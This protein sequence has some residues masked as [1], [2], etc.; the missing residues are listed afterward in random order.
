AVR[1]F[2]DRASRQRKTVAAYGASNT[3]TTLMYHFELTEDIAFLID[4]NTR[5]HGMFSPGRHLEVRPSSILYDAPPDVVMILAWQFADPIVAKHSRYV[6][7]GGQFVIPLPELR[8][9]ESG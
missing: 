4:D 5:K 8:T 3:V 6:A 7:N 2:V 9:I 1:E